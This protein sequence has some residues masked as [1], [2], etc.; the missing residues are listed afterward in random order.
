[1]QGNDIHEEV[2]SIVARMES[3]GE[4]DEQEEQSIPRIEGTV[5]IQD[6]YILVVRE[7]DEAPEQPQEEGI[8]ETTLAPQKPSLL[9]IA[10]C[11]FALLLPLASIVFQL[12]LAL[13][14]FTATVTIF[15]KSR[16]VTLSGT[17]QLGRIL[18]PITLSQSQAVPTS[19][20]GHQ[21]AKQAQGFITLYNGLFTSQTIHAGTILIG[22]DGVRIIT[23]QQAAIPA[24]NP[25]SLGYTT[26][27]AHALY[28]GG[29]GNIAAYD[30]NQACCATAIKAVNT[31]SFY[32]GADER[33]FQTV[34]HADIHTIATLLKTHLSQGL[35][36]ALQ[37]QLK[38][39]EV[40]LAPTC[41]PIVRSD[42]QPEDEAATVKVTVSETC[43]SAAYSTS[44]LQ[45]D[46]TLLLTSQAFQKLG[47]GYS[48][49]GNV[50]VVVK[51]ATIT[52]T[53]IHLVVSSQGTWIY[54]LST[55]AQEHI[56]QRIAGKTTHEALQLIASLPGIE[57]AAIKAS[58]FGDDTR[59]PKD[60]RNIQLVVISSIDQYQQSA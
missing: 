17:V 22:N 44:A 39:G 50:Q 54:K 55:K 51:Q 46:A 21:D 6:I 43:S 14:P 5:P 30:I 49:T 15:P 59:L 40:L 10:V 23:D 42:H 11:L 16:Q 19:G 41:T 58:G 57:T 3:A 56:R 36:S 47:A 45:K 34:S 52:G 4:E 20:K 32:W 28:A 9:A 33:N 31:A 29:R 26:V 8:I 12:S 18:H 53:H 13:N 38:N 25:P 24:A 60:P 2:N 37:K 1:M 7:H 48:L 27:S 35:T